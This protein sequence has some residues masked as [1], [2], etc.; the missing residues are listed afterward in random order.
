MIERLSRNPAALAGLLLVAVIAGAGA[1]WAM[2]NMAPG[3]PAASDKGRIEAVVRD[4]LLSHPEVIPEAMRKLQE[5][6][7]G[8][9]I[10]ANRAAILEP[11]GSAW[12]GNPKGD[13]TVVEYFDYNC[14]FCRS[15]LPTIAALVASDPKVKVVFREFPIL[16]AD[17]AVAARLSLAAA[18][19]G[20]F[21]R[22]HDALYAA[23][24][25]TPETM[26]AA[27]R[28]AGLDMA[29]AAAFAPQ[30]DAE[31]ASNRQVAQALGL[32]GTPSW[33][34]GDRVVS[35]A[36]PLEEL[37]KAVAAARNPS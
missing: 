23:G 37:Q 32:T 12:I 21:N 29:R 7:T 8:K 19:Q 34:I 22:F 28:K 15:S 17:S 36:L 11:F 9:V 10:A 25:V 20:K 35:A 18:A 30:A 3:S 26:A 31:I 13:V 24:P 4:Y 5:R 16:S 6:E 1:M 27:A 2:R 14:V 33:V